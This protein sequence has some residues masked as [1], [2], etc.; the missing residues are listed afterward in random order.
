MAGGRK[1]TDEQFWDLMYEGAGIYARVARLA[2]STYNVDITR[3]A[4]KQRAE[5]DREKL[6]DV[7]ESSVDTAEEGLQRHMRSKNEQVSLKA[8]IFVAETQGKDRGYTK[9]REYSG[10]MQLDVTEATGFKIKRKKRKS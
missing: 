3:Q 5:R 6:Q 2:K 4:I 1:L 7:K 9:K 8:C 10:N